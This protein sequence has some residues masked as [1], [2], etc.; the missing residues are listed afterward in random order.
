MTDKVT[1]TAEQNNEA[2]AIDHAAE[3]KSLRESKDAEIAELKAQV[4]ELKGLKAQFDAL[5]E[6]VEKPQLKAKLEETPK[7]QEHVLKK[8]ALDL[9]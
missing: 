6:L 3:L 2:P 7:V 8:N 1:A 9:I 4:A 5:K